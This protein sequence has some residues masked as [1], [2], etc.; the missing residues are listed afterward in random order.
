MS[1]ERR[2]FLLELEAWVVS[3]VSKA[4]LLARTKDEIGPRVL[5]ETMDLLERERAGQNVW[6]DLAFVEG[7]SCSRP[8]KFPSPLVN[9]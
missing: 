6:L 5:P 8:F 7:K 2:S 9:L 4:L 1:I 3:S